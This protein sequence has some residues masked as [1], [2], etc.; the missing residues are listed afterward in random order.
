MEDFAA[1]RLTVPPRGLEL[2]AEA[3]AIRCIFRATVELSGLE[4]PNDLCVYVRSF[5]VPD[6]LPPPTTKRTTRVPEDD[7]ELLSEL[8]DMG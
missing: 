7:P 6:V 2:I 4:R 5:G 8:E 1:E 3:D